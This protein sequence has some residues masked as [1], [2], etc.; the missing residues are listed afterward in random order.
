MAWFT[1]IMLRVKRS[2]QLHNEIQL[3]S[4]TIVIFYYSS[5]NKAPL[6]CGAK[7][8]WLRAWGDTVAFADIKAD[9]RGIY[10]FSFVASEQKPRHQQEE[11]Q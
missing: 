1:R 8:R 5:F 4:L 10:A 11:D 9:R 3:I 6:L 7:R 2:A